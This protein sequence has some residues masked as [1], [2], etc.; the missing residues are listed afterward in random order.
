MKCI[1]NYE[2]QAT[3]VLSPVNHFLDQLII[4]HTQRTS[5]IQENYI[6]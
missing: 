5:N 3:P 6:V 4:C 2:L 1:A